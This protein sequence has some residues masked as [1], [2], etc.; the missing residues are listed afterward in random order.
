MANEHR[1]IYKCEVCL[2]TSWAAEDCHGRAMIKCD[3]G[4]EGDD[5]TQPA[6]DYAGHLTSRAPKWWVFRRR[7]A[8]SIQT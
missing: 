6:T 5:C 1:I 3:A 2:R 8:A 4:C 7:R